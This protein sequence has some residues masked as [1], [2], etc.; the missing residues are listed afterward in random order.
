MFG[1]DWENVVNQAIARTT[2]QNT[3]IENIEEDQLY[4]GVIPRMINALFKELDKEENK[5][6]KF[7]VYCSFLQ[8]Y[9]EKIYDLLTVE[10]H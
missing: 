9:N 1:S 10:A 2:L 8:I 6:S 4:S 3:Y 7:T 5:A